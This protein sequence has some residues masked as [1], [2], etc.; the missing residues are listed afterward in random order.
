MNLLHRRYCR[1]EKWGALVAGQLLPWVLDGVDL[2]PSALEL[3]PGPGLTT[4]HLCHHT[5]RLT[6]VEVD[7]RD[8]AALAT[9]MQATNVAVVQ[10]DASAL[11]FADAT[12]SAVVA[13]TMLHHVASTAAQDR[14]FA[15]AFRVLG[16]SGSFCGC[17]S[18]PN[19]RWRAL[20]ILD[21][22]TVLHPGTLSTRLEAAGF[23]DVL[24]ETTPRRL[25]FRARRP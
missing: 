25:R 16:L 7:A 4:D 9:R 23:R 15:E 22:M 5:S 1:S 2:G 19:L 13:M 6:A 17:D 11:P 14:L 20:H 24:V 10:A 8:A 21:T 18:R 3:G 12:F